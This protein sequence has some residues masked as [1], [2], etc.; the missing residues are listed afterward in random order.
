MAGIVKNKTHSFKKILVRC[1]SW[2]GDVVMA[3]P[4]LESL[5]DAYPTAHITLMLREYAREVLVGS[6]FYNDIISIPTEA[7]KSPFLKKIGFSLKNI[8]TIRTGN[9]DCAV[10]LTNS[11]ESAFEVFCAGVRYRLGYRRDGRNL[12]LSEGPHPHRKNGKFV[13]GPMVDYYNHL[14]SY[15]GFS[16]YKDRMSLAVSPEEQ[17]IAEPVLRQLGINDNDMLIGLNPGGAFGA[18]KFW[19]SD[20]FAYIGDYFA[21]QQGIQV[22]LL[23]GP[24]E[25]P[26][27]NK[28]AATMKYPVLRSTPDKV[29]IGTLKMMIKKM[30]L[31]ITNDTG[32]RHFA[33]ACGVPSIVLI[34]STNPKWTENSDPY[35]VVLQRT[36]LCGPCHKKICP[37]NH[38]C[39]KSIKPQ[40][41]IDTAESLLEA[42][43]HE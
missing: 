22:I 28:I 24:G 33:T 30:S 27:V 38:Q 35:Q 14:G 3:T 36:P 26:I 13:P 31:L 43:V 19:P 18:S 2:I 41:V 20:Y 42:V 23:A 9:F 21:Q 25:E 29:T 4:F 12:L 5:R 39:M 7:K 40:E 17:S 1:P 32:P 6:S 8:K 34:G 10:L 16:Q 15:L 11:F 37:L